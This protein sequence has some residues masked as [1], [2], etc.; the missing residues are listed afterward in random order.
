MN[1][2]MQTLSNLGVN[3]R[4]G[5]WEE[6]KKIVFPWRGV[7]DMPSRQINDFVQK[8]KQKE[9]CVS[10]QTWSC[11]S[12][13]DKCHLSKWHLGEAC[14]PIVEVLWGHSL[15]DLL[16]DGVG[17]LVMAIPWGRPGD[18]VSR[19]HVHGLQSGF[20]GLGELWGPPGLGTNSI[21]I[22][23]VSILQKI[24]DLPGGKINDPSSG[25]H[26]SCV[27]N[28][29]HTV[30]GDM[31]DFLSETC[32]YYKTCHTILSK[33]RLEYRTHQLS[34]DVTMTSFLLW[35]NKGRFKT[36]LKL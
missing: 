32:L 18:L 31:P 33:T 27:L 11:G 2:I 10:G 26:Y 16:V 35:S 1:P 23:S 5:C 22:F 4:G 3:S 8:R 20:D 29:S 24:I 34:I 6:R 13:V 17:G 12:P 19:P 9:N 30:L 14:Q 28:T 15:G 7:I 21:L 25:K 36:R